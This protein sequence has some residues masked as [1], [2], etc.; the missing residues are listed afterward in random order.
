MAAKSYSFCTSNELDT[1]FVDGLKAAEKR[2]GRANFSYVVVQALKE[3]G[4]RKM[5]ERKEFE[6]FKKA[7][8]NG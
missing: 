4:S 8:A 7:K 6:E 5:Q 2:E 1:A 3:Y